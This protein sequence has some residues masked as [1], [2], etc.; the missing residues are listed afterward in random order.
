MGNIQSIL[1]SFNQQDNLN[2]KIWYLPK[3]KY[4]GDPDGQS[5]MMN[6]KVRNRLLEIANEFVNFLD[7]DIIVSD[8]LMTGSLANY[9]WSKYSDIDLHILTDFNQFSKKELPLYEELFRLKKTIYNDKHDIT[10]YGYDVELYVQNESESH[11]SSG[12][13]SVLND[14]WLVTPKKE[15]IKIDKK[16]IKSKAQQWMNIIDG[17]VENIE[18]ESIEEANKILKKYKEKLKKY[19][20]CGLEKGGE[21]SDENIVFKILRRN[22]YIE[23]L[24]NSQNKH[25]DKLLS[26]KESTT[27]IGGVFKTDLENGPKNHGSRAFGNWQSDNAWDVFAPAGTLVNSYTK[28]KVSKIRDT[29]KN[30]GKVYGTQVSIK[31]SDGYPDIF[32]T[33]LK[34]VELKPGDEV[35]VGDR[36]GDISEWTNN[37]NM[38]H[39]HIGL[40]YGKHLRDLLKNSEEI[41]AGKT[42]ASKESYKEVQTKFLNPVNSTNISSK[43][44][45]RWGKKHSGIDIAVPSGTNVISPAN[46]IV[47][48]SEIRNNSCGGT[49]FIDH[50]NGLKSRYCHLKKIDVKK[51]DTIAQGDSL[52]LTGGAKGDIGSGNSGGAHLHFELYENGKPVDPE[53]YIKGGKTITT[54]EPSSTETPTVNTG[55]ITQDDLINLF[56]GTIGSL[57]KQ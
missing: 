28:G 29:G 26:L 40:P 31:G 15:N 46:G 49:L 18:D 36:I 3:E 16:L 44:G 1:S 41:F 33:H 42:T 21:Y 23:K 56:S 34:N 30:S 20:T 17:V 57:F 51:G 8:V 50:G 48:D 12:V 35:N 11:F 9:N 54:I 37:N 52:G 5:Y 45:S 25:S 53:P 47:V 2:P 55:T 10:I 24:Y 22:G 6:P 4:M 38:T 39:V 27:N 32:Y 19:R 14:E 43:F 7:V 13:F